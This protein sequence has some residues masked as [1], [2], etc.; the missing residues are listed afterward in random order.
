[1]LLP[2]V[3]ASREAARRS[4]C[5][6]NLK[7]LSLAVLKYHDQCQH[8]PINE[9]YSALRTR[10]CDEQSGQELGYISIQDDP[11]RSP[12]N[13]LDG[14]GWIV[15]VLPQVEEEPLYDRLRVGMKGRVANTNGT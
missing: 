9:D 15:R 2:A 13:K 5:S 4:S 12:T 7:N 6:N 8:F 10:H 14:G 1:M 11:W 3:Q